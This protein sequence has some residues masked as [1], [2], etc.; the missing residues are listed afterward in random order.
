MNEKLKGFLKDVAEVVISVAVI[1]FIL[2]HFILIPVRVDGTSMFP[3]LHDGDFG[4][5]FIIKKNLGVRRFDVAIID[6]S[7]EEYEKLL[8]KRVIGLPGETV[9]Y[10][11]SKLY[12]NGEYV[13]EDFLEEGVKTCTLSHCRNDASDDFKVELQEGE[14]LCLGDNRTNSRDS[15]YYGAF[16]KEKIKATGLFVFWPLND[17]GFK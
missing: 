13:E 16:P 8:V 12:I 4:Y 2:L 17:L 14:Y 5:S 7:E 9:E 1:S 3:Y 15:R 11:D 6:M 10:R